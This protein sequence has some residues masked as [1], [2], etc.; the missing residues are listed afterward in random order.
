MGL[1]RLRLRVVYSEGAAVITTEPQI[2]ETYASMEE[3][4]LIKRYSDCGH[5]RKMGWGCA[6]CNE[7]WPQIFSPFEVCQ[8]CAEIV[9][10]QKMGRLM[11]A[12]HKG[13][14]T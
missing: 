2:I 9:Q 14:D 7:F 8:T 3:F 4:G 1:P 11:M 12:G 13:D 10:A 5:T 6:P